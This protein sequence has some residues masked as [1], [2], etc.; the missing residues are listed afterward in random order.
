MVPVNPVAPAMLS[1]SGPSSIAK[2]SFTSSASELTPPATLRVR[3]GKSVL[4]L[5]V[6]STSVRLLL[7]SIVRVGKLLVEMAGAASHLSFV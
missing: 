7:S 3:D 4:L 2:V 6:I 1:Q 5:V